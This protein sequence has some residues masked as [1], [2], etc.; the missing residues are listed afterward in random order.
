M[1][2][3]VLAAGEGVRCAPLTNTRSKVMLPVANRPILEYVISALVDNGIEDVVLVVGYEK[4]KVMNYFGDGNDFGA[5]ITYVDQTSQLG[6]AHAISQAIPALGND[7][8]SFLVLNGDNIIEKETINKLITNH[9]GDATVLTTPREKVC[10]YG[11]VMS[12]AGKVK[13]IFEKPTRQ[14]S[15]MVNTGIYAFNRDI[16]AEIDKTEISERGEYEITHT[17]QNMVKKDRDVRVIVTKNL[18]MDSVYAWDLLD[19]NARLLANCESNISDTSV[20]YES[21]TL[22]GDVEIGD[23]TVIR[24]GSYI[25]GPIKIGSNCDIGPQVTVLPCTSIGD[26]VSLGPYTYIQNSILMDNVRVESHSHVSES[27]IGFYCNFGPYSI[28]EADN[29]VN[30]EIENELVPVEKSGV[31][32]GDDCK[33]GSRTLTEAGTLVGNNCTVRSGT[34]VDRHL[35]ANSTV[36]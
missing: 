29:D 34:N 27:I 24:P 2:A 31:V 7:N 33:F 35:P 15:H 36:L 25:V 20:V 26:N 32:I 28:C 4:E 14:I 3:I 9:A 12:A 16:I 8:E 21:V 10:G 1:K 11:V 18:W 22:V 19:I 17:L 30:I 13:G 5:R 6:T 23:D